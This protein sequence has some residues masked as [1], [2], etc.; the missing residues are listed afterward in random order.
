MK[1]IVLSFK[2]IDVSKGL[3]ELVKKYP[4]ATVCFPV[5][6]D[7]LFFNSVIQVCQNNKSAFH[8]YIPDIS[9]EVT[10]HPFNNNQ[11]TVSDDP[12]KD[13]LRNVN[14]EDILAIAWDDGIECHVALHSV[15]DYGME[16][17]DISDGLDPIEIDYEHSE[18]TGE[19]FDDMMDTMQTF[20]EKMALYITATVLESLNQV[21]GEN[22]ERLNDIDPFEE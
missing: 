9:S 22:L 4:N 14:S 2:D 12:I 16:T 13:I 6:G 20:V 15:E 3:D 17:W 18:V 7:D 1:I 8:C 10:V 21:I 11:V 5:M 19:L